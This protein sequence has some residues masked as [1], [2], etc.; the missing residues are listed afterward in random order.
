[1]L[2]Q[3]LIGKT[4]HWTTLSTLPTVPQPTLQIKKV[5]SQQKKSEGKSSKGKKGLPSRLASLLFRPSRNSAARQQWSQASAGDNVV[6]PVTPTGGGI[7]AVMTDGAVCEVVTSLIVF[8]GG[9]V[10]EGFLQTDA[11][12]S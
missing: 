10:A 3:Q 2:S 12:S 4:F 1:V 5:T 7:G 9:S 8:F 6:E 11:S